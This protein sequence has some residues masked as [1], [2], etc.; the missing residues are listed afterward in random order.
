M[1]G[2]PNVHSAALAWWKTLRPDP[3]SGHKGD[4]GA[5]ARLRRATL[6]G[7]ALEPATAELYRR[8]RPFLSANEL[9]AFETAALVA[10]VLA[11]V[12]ELDNQR[13][14]RAAGAAGEKPARVSPFRFRKILATRGGPDCLIAFRR[15]VAL[16]DR[17]ANV[18]DLAASLVEWNEP[19]IGD[20]RRTRWAFDY[21]DAGNVVPAAPD[22]A[23]DE[24]QD[25]A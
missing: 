20:R 22:E 7:A 25:A 8:V 3:G 24:A 4:T 19:G 21:Y 14:A 23:Q 11:H 2:K 9:D 1:T 17:Q 5:L 16:L 10:A 12:R 18:G 13:I 6:Q 15:L